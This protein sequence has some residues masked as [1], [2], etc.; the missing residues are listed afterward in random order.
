MHQ[1]RPNA[2]RMFQ[3]WMASPKP[4]LWF[5]FLICLLPFLLF[6]SILFDITNLILL[7][8][9]FCRRGW[10]GGIEWVGLGGGGGGGV[11]FLLGD[12]YHYP[13]T[14]LPAGAPVEQ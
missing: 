4:P 13:D 6:L 12:H 11:G 2:D 8:V 10:C 5:G 9:S 1:M 14:H 3:L 7:R